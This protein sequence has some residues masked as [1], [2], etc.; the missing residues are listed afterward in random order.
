M[1]PKHPQQYPRLVPRI[2]EQRRLSHEKVKEDIEAF[3]RSGGRIKKLPTYKQ[4][5]SR[6]IGSKDFYG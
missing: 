6:R 3:L 5:I 4:Q 2:R 1:K